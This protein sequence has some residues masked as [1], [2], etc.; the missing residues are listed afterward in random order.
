MASLTRSS[1]RVLRRGAR[2]A[3]VANKPEM[4]SAIDA[5]RLSLASSTKLLPAANFLAPS[6][7]SSSSS[8]SSIFPSCK[9]PYGISRLMSTQTEAKDDDIEVDPD[10]HNIIDQSETVKGESVSHEFQAETRRLL[11]IAAKSLYSDKEVFLRELISNASDALEKLRHWHL[12]QQSDGEMAPLE[13]HIGTDEGKKTLIIQ[14]TGIG[15]SKEELIENL[16][17]IARSGTKKFLEEES[18]KTMDASS[19]IGQFGVG[20]Y[21]TFM[22]GHK[23]E[24]FSRKMGEDVGYRWSS[25]GSGVFDLAETEGLKVGSKIVIHLNGEAQEFAKEDHVKEIVEKYSN[26]VS[27]PIFLNGKKVNVLEPLWL[28]NSSQVTDEMHDEF[29][30]FISKA[31]DSPRFHLHYKTDSPIS[32]RSIFYFPSHKPGVFELSRETDLTDRGIAL[33]SRRVLIQPS[34]QHLLPK[35]LRWVKGVVDSEDIPLNLSRELLQDSALIKKLS[36]VLTGR[37]IKFLA[38]KAKKHPEDYAKFYEDYGFFIREGVVTSNEQSEKEEVAKLLR[39]ESSRKPAGETVSLADYVRGMANTQRDI[40]YLAAP[41]R[42][43]AE[44]SPYMEAMKEK[45]VEVL[46]CYE[47]Y[48]DLTMLQLGQ[49]DKK[50]LKS[51]E[52]A[53]QEDQTSSNLVDSSNPLSLSQPD[54]DALTGWLKDRVLGERVKDVKV[55]TRLSTHPV[56]VTVPQLGAV[57]H[58]LQTSMAKIPEEEK[59]RMMQ[60]SFEVNPTHDLVKSLHRLRTEDPQVAEL[61]ALQ[62]FDNAMVEAGL[63]DDPRQFVNRINK[64]LNMVLKEKKEESEPKE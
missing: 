42:D 15:M 47:Q 55:S 24:V 59:Y 50:S 14:D 3:I 25:D 2:S 19:L 58:F 33:Y 43:M 40:Y 63:A 18:A 11:E 10:Y 21:S 6:A 17:T 60:C 13:I 4:M 9:T 28:M 61:V 30:R 45:D 1:V 56:V 38:D 44:N 32:I 8:S 54:A 57:R 35:W 27:A 29:Y 7:L 26:F 49:F 48:D 36:T 22:V 34:N 39:F 31:Y 51:I 53:V 46:F 20:F 37:I 23:V 62:L 5:R 12:Q 64:I 52:N 41:T 16:G